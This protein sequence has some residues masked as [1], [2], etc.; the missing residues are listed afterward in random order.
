MI[1]FILDNQKLEA[2]INPKNLETEALVGGGTAI[3]HPYQ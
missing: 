2:V 3:V 1:C